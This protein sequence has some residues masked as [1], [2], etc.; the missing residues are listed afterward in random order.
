MWYTYRRGSGIFY[1]LGRTKSAPGKTALVA[2]LLKVTPSNPSK[3]AP[4]P[5]TPPLSLKQ[6][7]HKSLQELARRPSLAKHWPA[8]AARA[9]LFSA[10]APSAGARADAER[11]RSVANGSAPCAERRVE[12]CRCRYVLN[13]AWDDAL[14]W[15]ARA[16]GY[17]T[18]FLTATLLCDGRGDGER[19]ASGGERAFV[20]AYPELV[21]VRPLGMAMVEEQARGVH[22]YLQHGE[23]GE[24]RASRK[25]PEAADEWIAQMR[26]DGTLSLRDPFDVAA[27]GEGSQ[28]PCEFSVHRWTLQCA[29]HLSSR[30][31]TSGWSRCGLAQCNA[32]GG[33]IYGRIM[34]QLKR[35]ANASG[36]VVGTRSD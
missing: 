16:L 6:A 2:A 26:S 5:R 35:G 24:L 22:G 20:T 29:G 1:R 9:G 8:M 30:W 12:A 18:L 21:D 25:R 11:L 31:P 19:T 17:E 15:M 28:R 7:A 34:N 33:G 13:D 27:V 14:T 36:H 32:S 4:A 3:R 23:R 10:S